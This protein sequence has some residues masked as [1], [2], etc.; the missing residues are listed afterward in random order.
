MNTITKDQLIEADRLATIYAGDLRGKGWTPAESAAVT[1]ARVM[2]LEFQNGELNRTCL[3]VA[4]LAAWA[5]TFPGNPE[6]DLEFSPDCTGN[7]GSVTIRRDAARA[8]FFY[9]VGSAKTHASL[10]E[11]PAI[12]F[13]DDNHKL[14][15]FR[16]VKPA[17]M[18][19]LSNQLKTAKAAKQ[20]AKLLSAE[21]GAKRNLKQA[22][23]E[24]CA[25]LDKHAG[26]FN[27]AKTQARA[28]LAARR[29][30]RAALKNPTA[31]QSWIPGESIENGVHHL[32]Q[33]HWQLVANVASAKT[34]LAEYKPRTRY[35]RW[36]REKKY[37][38]KVFGPQFEVLKSAVRAAESALRSYLCR[39]FRAYCAAQGLPDRLAWENLYGV[40]ELFAF[41]RA[42]IA[43]RQW[44]ARKAALAA[45]YVN[46]L[47]ARRKA[48]G[49]AMAS[50]AAVRAR[51]IL[52]TGQ[53]LPAVLM[54]ADFFAGQLE[55]ASAQGA[56]VEVL[57]SCNPLYPVGIIPPKIEAQPVAA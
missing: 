36:D 16:L 49:K 29:M 21:I 53:V 23:H 42:R 3:P 46:T 38:E 13:D 15:S 51:A 35:A 40:K 2:R 50:G 10:S 56:S 48:Q 34:W 32:T 18:G 24:H 17:D 1:T 4:K 8:T 14:P 22:A 28:M 6:F 37:G 41:T 45:E 55:K 39:E 26:G 5:R 30:F 43:V 31:A 54:S 33:D 47:N 25:L 44:P 9:H 52:K 11:V 57:E 12:R 19:E 7:G 27:P 20:F